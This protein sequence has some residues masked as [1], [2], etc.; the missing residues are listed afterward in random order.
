MRT[1]GTSIEKA[2]KSNKT[3]SVKSKRL[4]STQYTIRFVIGSVIAYIIALLTAYIVLITVDKYAGHK[5][6]FN[7]IAS[8]VIV[9][10][11]TGITTVLNR[12]TPP[13]SF[14][15]YIINVVRSIL[16]MILIIIVSIIF[17]YIGEKLAYFAFK[18]IHPDKLREY[19]SYCLGP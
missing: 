19:Q 8:T 17:V 13:S 6:P 15:E 2:A 5:T 1:Y 12:L 11:I 7:I 4:T 10:N 16:I 9:M 18:T 14:S 3:T